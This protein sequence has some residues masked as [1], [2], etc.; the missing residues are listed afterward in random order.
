MIGTAL[1]VYFIV[2]YMQVQYSTVLVQFYQ[3]GGEG[4]GKQEG[5]RR[6]KEEGDL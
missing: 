1:T 5:K 4:R 2:W 3:R 6:K